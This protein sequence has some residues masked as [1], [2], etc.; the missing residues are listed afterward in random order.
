MTILSLLGPLM[1]Q[2]FSYLSENSA[3]LN[4][5]AHTK[6]LVEAASPFAKKDDGDEICFDLREAGLITCLGDHFVDIRIS[7]PRLLQQG[8]WE[9]SPMTPLRDDEW[10]ETGRWH[11]EGFDLWAMLEWSPTTTLSLPIFSQD[12]DGHRYISSQALS[13]L[14]PSQ[15]DFLQSSPAA[16]LL[17]LPPLVA[18]QDFPPDPPVTRG[19]YFDLIACQFRPSENSERHALRTVH[20]DQALGTVRLT[21]NQENREAVHRSLKNKLDR[22]QALQVSLREKGPFWK[23]GGT[24]PHILETIHGM[25]AALEAN[26]LPRVVRGIQSLR[27]LLFFSQTHDI[28]F[29]HNDSDRYFN[30]NMLSVLMRTYLQI[31]ETAERAIDFFQRADQEDSPALARLGM[32]EYRDLLRYIR[33]DQWDGLG[34]GKGPDEALWQTY[35]AAG[36]HLAQDSVSHCHEWETGPGDLWTGVCASYVALNVFGLG[37]LHG[38]DNDLI[39]DEN[40]KDRPSTEFAK[41]LSLEFLQVAT[42][43]DTAS[44]S[45][46]RD[47]FLNHYYPFPW[48]ERPL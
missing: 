26:D 16:L 40:E 45:T 42:D 2:G 3:L 20:I 34:K 13:L 38:L 6:D 37:D 47:Q 39:R 30:K 9:Q 12:E 7:D 41:S 15:F 33:E 18:E 11:L 8:N 21:T 36:L 19:T 17:V 48:R 46:R 35:L 4:Y 27:P 10:Q 23:E 22:L 31:A 43:P 44:F 1:S 24:L 14:E 28:V 32:K 5:P 29:P 25:A